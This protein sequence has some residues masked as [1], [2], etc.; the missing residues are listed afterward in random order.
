MVCSCPL[1]ALAL[2]SPGLRSA[3]TC[4]LP[5]ATLHELQSNLQYADTCAGL[6]GSQAMNLAWLLLVPW[7]EPFSKRNGGWGFAEAGCCLF[8][9][10]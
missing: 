9:R 8:E 2:R 7:L 3:T 10:I 1:G 5:K 4:L 6:G